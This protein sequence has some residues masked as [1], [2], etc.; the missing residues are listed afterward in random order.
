M[1]EPPERRRRV[2][3]PALVSC[4]WPGRTRRVS[5]SE[6]G[7]R[8]CLMPERKR[9]PARGEASGPHA[10][11]HSLSGPL[12]RGA[13]ALETSSRRRGASP[14]ALNAAGRSRADAAGG[15]TLSELRRACWDMGGG[16]DRG[17]TGIHHQKV[18]NWGKFCGEALTKRIELCP[19]QHFWRSR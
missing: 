5:N 18:V 17:Q 8:L 1:P 12:G 4:P 9:Q 2:W 10:L 11:G 7:C 19:S 13:C 14:A 6:G 15:R 16:M 3:S